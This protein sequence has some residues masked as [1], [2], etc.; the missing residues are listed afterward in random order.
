M[1]G[2]L[3][4]ATTLV[5]TLG[6]S[7]VGRA[8]T[9]VDASGQTA[10]TT[11][12]FATGPTGPAVTFG[13]TR[14]D[15]AD[16]DGD[17]RQDGA[18]IG[19]PSDG[20]AA[21]LARVAVRGTG[22]GPAEDAL[23]SLQ[24]Q[25]ERAVDEEA[26]AVRSAADLTQQASELERRR[27]ELEGTLGRLRA[28]QQGAADRAAEARRQADIVR[29]YLQA[30]AAAAYMGY[31]SEGP[32]AVDPAALASARVATGERRATY[33]RNVLAQK[34]DER[35]GYLDAED[36]ANRDEAAK[37]A[38]AHD[39]EVD[40]GSLAGELVMNHA[41]ADQV[42]QRRQDALE[43]QDELRRRL[44]AAELALARARR[45]GTVVGL[46]LPLVVLDALWKASA[47]ID[48]ER[49]A[50]HLSWSLLAGISKVESG[51]GTFGGAVVDGS[52]HVSPP[53]IGVAL[54]GSGVALIGD[55]DGGRYDRDP[56][57]D[58]AVGPM[59][60]IPSSW[61]IF[62]RDGDGDGLRDPQDY[63]DAAQAA[64]DHLCRG[65]ADTATQEGRR[66][67]VLSYNQ[68]E[69]YVRTVVGYA[70]AYARFVVPG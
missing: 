31:G 5:A 70:D 42:E 57:F 24:G 35:R 56:T 16:S 11:P 39:V 22:V 23:S 7:A 27:Q 58:R 20:V 41:A 1:L 67:A 4:V 44:P 54:D 48:A 61:A 49:P 52:G 43:R 53:I 66:A 59:Q 2:A 13:D 50:C 33:A 65:G 26:D 47:A 6:P 14:Q 12:T 30:L 29:D 45:A 21:A 69:D 37:T 19:G 38:A 8:E 15:G 34:R 9:A 68:S 60:F 36:A 18:E 46:D 55:T 10:T 25:I 3:V 63:Y 62:G 51:H 28:E 32:A 64:A 17:A 40:L